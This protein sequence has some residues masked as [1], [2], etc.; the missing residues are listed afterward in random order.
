M[1]RMAHPHTMQPS[2]PGPTRTA[3]PH[4]PDKFPL[5]GRYA[6]YTAF[7][8]TSLFY[9]AI[10]LLALR[11]VWALG[12]GPEAFTAVMASFQ[13]PLYLLFH[14]LCIPVCLFVSYRF[15]IKLS[16]KAQPP[17]VGPVRPPPPAAIP[18]LFGGLFL[19]AT[20]VAVAVLWGVVL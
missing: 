9:G 11:L 6:S 3:P 10:S 5:G 8:A 12:D 7:G 20:V 19:G 2:T 1:A 16:G 18:A 17:K 14:A 15:L 4:M 13:N